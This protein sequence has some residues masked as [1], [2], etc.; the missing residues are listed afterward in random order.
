MSNR[1]KKRM[2]IPMI[3]AVLVLLCWP[4]N[5]SACVLFYA[6]GDMTDDG[7]NLFIRSEEV[8]PDDNKTYYISH[9]VK[10]AEGEEYQ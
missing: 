2:F 8:G 9:A 4:V 6:G 5:A 3:V 1:Q 7:A 10:H